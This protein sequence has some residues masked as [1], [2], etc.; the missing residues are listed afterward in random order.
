[1][2]TP[3]VGTTQQRDPETL[4]LTGSRVK[5]RIQEAL[6]M[7]AWLLGFTAVSAAYHVGACALGRFFLD[8]FNLWERKIPSNASPLNKHAEL[9]AALLASCLSTPVAVGLLYA[10][11]AVDNVIDRRRTKFLFLNNVSDAV[12]YVILTEWSL[13]P[14]SGLILHPRLEYVNPVSILGVYWFGSL[15]LLPISIP[16]ACLGYWVMQETD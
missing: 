14:V 3:R 4:R 12:F 6:S 8:H 10:L 13:L 2:A 5:Y 7:I 9:L 16:L 11:L 15:V 1:M